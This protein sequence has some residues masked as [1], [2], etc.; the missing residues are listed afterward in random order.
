[1]QKRITFK[2]TFQKTGMAATR[3]LNVWLTESALNEIRKNPTS[4]L[5]LMAH[6]LVNFFTG[7]DHLDVVKL[8][9][10]EEDS[11][12]EWVYDDYRKAVVL[13]EDYEGPTYSCTGCQGVCICYAR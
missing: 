10:E 2:L 9:M 1:M 3:Y 11:G 8:T 4:H 6:V 7:L 5:T 13:P 12:F